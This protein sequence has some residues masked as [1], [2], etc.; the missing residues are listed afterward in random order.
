[1]RVEVDDRGL[2]EWAAPDRG[3]ATFRS[4]EEVAEARPALAGLVREW[5]A[6]TAGTA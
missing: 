5:I 4:V 6:A 2:L 1:V 3:S